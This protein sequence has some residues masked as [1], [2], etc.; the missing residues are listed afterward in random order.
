MPT[1]TPK[2]KPDKTKAKPKAKRKFRA[3][4]KPAPKPKHSRDE[5]VLDMEAEQ[6]FRLWC[7]IKDKGKGGGFKGVAKQFGRD[8]KTVRRIA[9]KDDW[10]GRY[11]KI[12]ADVQKHTDRKIVKEEISNLRLVRRLRDKIATEKLRSNQ[13]IDAS[14][15]DF[16][17]VM[18]YQDELEGNLPEPSQNDDREKLLSPDQIDKAIVML[19]KMGEKAID[20][21]GQVLVEVVKQQRSSDE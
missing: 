7:Q 14:V 13:D 18:R 12:M 8:I 19:E 3:K 20:R 5:Y 17:D 2:K 16:L 11:A 6:M 1:R 10:R 21:F 9:E 15:K 4:P